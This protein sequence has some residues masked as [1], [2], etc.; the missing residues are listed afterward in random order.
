LPLPSADSP[1]VGQFACPTLGGDSVGSTVMGN[2]D[3]YDRR[4]VL[5]CDRPGVTLAGLVY[6]ACNPRKRLRQSGCH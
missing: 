6:A 3:V 1:R 2:L 4:V 5:I